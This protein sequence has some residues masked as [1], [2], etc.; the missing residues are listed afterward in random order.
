M[1]PL[2]REWVKFK[3][4]ADEIRQATMIGADSAMTSPDTR[5]SQPFQ[6]P[7][8]TDRLRR[9]AQ[10]QFRIAAEPA[11]YPALARFLGVDAVERL[12]LAGFVAAHGKDGW[13]IRGQL[14]AKVVQTCVVTLEP[15]RNR[16]EEEIERTYVPEQQARH[17]PEV[18][19]LPDED[20]AP[21]HFSDS[22][23]PA[24]L[25]VESLALSID[26]YPRRQG[27]ELDSG[28]VRMQDSEDDPHETTRPFAGLA[29]LLRRSGAGGG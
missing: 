6:R 2:L 27:A 13:R 8:R 9:D 3:R 11:E 25:A 21:D 28:T 22:I 7:I 14:V 26:P 12:T 20:D 15:I 19:L 18:I 24:Q 23:D 1:F 5:Q 16:I 17:Q 29:D 10:T 4:P